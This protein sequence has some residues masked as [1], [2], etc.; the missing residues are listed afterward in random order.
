M[1]CSC[2]LGHATSK[3]HKISISKWLTG[4]AEMCVY[5]TGTF[6]SLLALKWCASLHGMQASPGSLET[7]HLHFLSL[8][9]LESQKKKEGRPWQ[10]QLIAFVRP[11]C[12]EGESVAEDRKPSQSTRLQA[13]HAHVYLS[14]PIRFAVRQKLT[15]N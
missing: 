1:T 6:F 3:D 13:R 9:G 12:S 8:S 4:D 5:L 11:Q 10:S 14:T 2:C 15:Q 7:Q